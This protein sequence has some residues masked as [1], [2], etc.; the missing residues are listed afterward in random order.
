MTTVSI[1]PNNLR[2]SIKIPPSKSMSHRAIIC[3]SLAEGESVVSN[4]IF[5]KDIE[6]SIGAMQAFGAEFERG[7]DFVIVNGIKSKNEEKCTIDCNE[8]GSTIR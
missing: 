8:S 6:A 1:K 5:S 7:E 3:A 4:L 2:G